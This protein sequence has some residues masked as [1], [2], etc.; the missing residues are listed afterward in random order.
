MYRHRCAKCSSSASENDGAGGDEGE[1]KDASV[2]D[3]EA[4]FA[5]FR[6]R[7][8]EVEQQALQR[9][10]AIDK[11]WKDGR[12]DVKVGAIANDWVRRVILVD[13]ELFVGTAT[14]GIQRY[15]LGGDEP[16]QIFSVSGDPTRMVPADHQA[17]IRGSCR[18]LL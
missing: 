4:F 14:R 5:A 12:A 17:L 2:E 7:A 18:F 13:D 10:A 8:Q 1:G 16:R 3:D 9:R 15:G 11:N 6:K